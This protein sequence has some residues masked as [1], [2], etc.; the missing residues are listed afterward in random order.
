MPGNGRRG[1]AARVVASAGLPVALGA[2]LLA[3]SGGAAAGDDVPDS[4]RGAARHDLAAAYAPGPAYM[5]RP[6]AGHTGGF[7]EPACQRCHFD[8]PVNPPEA[9]LEIRGFPGRFRPDSTYP[10]TVLMT[11]PDLGRAGFEAAVRCAGGGDE[12]R[13]AGRL[14]AAGPRVEVVQGEGGELAG[15]STVQYAR[16]TGEGSRTTAP[17]TATWRVVWAAPG[18]RAATESGRSGGTVDGGG[19]TA[20]GAACPS[21]VLHAAANAADGD[22]SEFGDRIVT[23]AAVSVSAMGEGRTEP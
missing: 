5:D 2:G 14:S 7:G 20:P 16:H 4:E 15:D 17:D 8:A 18:G 23:L 1:P 10:L 12:G 21:A 11:A 9:R 3:A 19:S 22:T 6:P 13:Q